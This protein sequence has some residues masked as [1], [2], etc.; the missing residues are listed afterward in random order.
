M[1]LTDLYAKTPVQNHKDIKVSGNK[2][3]VKQED[4]VTEYLLES[5]GELWLLPSPIKE[6][7]AR[8]KQLEQSLAE[9]KAIMTR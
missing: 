5:N 1:N 8:V 2:V 4:E 6:V 3:F 9:L 7:I